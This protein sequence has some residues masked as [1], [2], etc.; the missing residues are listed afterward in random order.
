M[1]YEITEKYNAMVIT[2]EKK[3]MGGPGAEDFAN[4]I[5]Q[6]LESGKKNIIADLSGVGFV[7][8]TGIGILIRT[9]TTVK[10]A[11]GELKL[12]GM[13]EKIEGLLSITKL[14]SVFSIYS[15]AEEAANS[16]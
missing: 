5:S 2:F 9:F 12:A 16:F 6:L 4:E 3:L 7:N 8:S 15:T 10:N 11:G 14:N 13:S 1:K